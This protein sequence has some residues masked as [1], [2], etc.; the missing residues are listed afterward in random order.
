[1]KM[2]QI[3]NN[4]IEILR[5]DGGW[6]SFDVPKEDVEFWRIVLRGMNR[7]LIDQGGE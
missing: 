1:M 3:T 5:Y 6:T 2:Y 4:H 7:L